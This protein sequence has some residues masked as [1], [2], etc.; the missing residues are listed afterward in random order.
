MSFD[1]K[2]QTQFLFSENDKNQKF[3]ENLFKSQLQNQEDII[4]KRLEERKNKFDRSTSQPPQK[5]RA[6]ETTPVFIKSNFKTFI[7]K[8]N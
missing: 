1:K 7:K 3:Q 8:I 6:E 4:R 5:A 2:G